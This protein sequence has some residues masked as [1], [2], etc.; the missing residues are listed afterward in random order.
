MQ[1]VKPVV[2]YVVNTEKIEL[3]LHIIY[4]KITKNARSII[5]IFVV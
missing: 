3:L 5:E 2:N 1:K 4:S